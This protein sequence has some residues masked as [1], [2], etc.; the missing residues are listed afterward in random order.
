MIRIYQLTLLLSGSLVLSSCKKDKIET[1]PLTS[2]TVGNFVAG[3]ASIKIGSIVTTVANNNTNGTQMAL[4]AGENDLYVWPVGDS[5][6]PYFTY[7]KFATLEG[8]VYS[9]FLC[10]V[11]GTTEGIV[12]KEN[13][14]YRTDSTAGIRFINL[15]P[16]STP[17]NITKSTSTTLNEVSNLA[18]KQYTDYISYPALST[19]T[20]TFQVRAAANPNTVLTTFALSTATIPRFTNITV[21]IRGVVGGTPAIGTTRVNQD[22]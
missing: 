3:G 9:L 6:H 21:V 13:I 16:N 10:G 20:Y 22:R 11:P 14:P 15:S 5:L 1:I 12:I 7:P 18:Y 4:R 8:E 17:L 19:S 2:I